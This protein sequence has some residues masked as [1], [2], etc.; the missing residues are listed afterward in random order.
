MTDAQTYEQLPRFAP[1][2]RQCS[3]EEHEA[4][5]DFAGI[6][7]RLDQMDLLSHEGWWADWGGCMYAETIIR[8]FGP[9]VASAAAACDAGD[10]GSSATST[11][12]IIQCADS[13]LQWEELCASSDDREAK[14]LIRDARRALTALGSHLSTTANAS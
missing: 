10:E 8:D 11:A 5:P 12:F 9:L 4:G 6:A 14:H 2:E 7:S 3:D 13:Y 1:H